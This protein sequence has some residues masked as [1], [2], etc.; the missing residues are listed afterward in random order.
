MGVQLNFNATTVEPTGSLDPIPPADYPVVLTDSEVCETRNRDGHYLK[1]TF[2]V[3]GGEHAGRQLF[4]N[5]NLWHP[6]PVASEIAWRELSGL[7]HAANVMQVQD[8][9]QLHGIPVMAKVKIEKGKDGYDDSNRISGFKN[10]NEAGGAGAGAPQGAPAQAPGG[11]PPQQPPGQGAQ[12]PQGGAAPWQQPGQQG[13]P[14][15]G[16]PPQQAAP[17]AQPPQQ[18]APPQQAQPPQ[19]TQE[20]PAQQAAPPQGD[21]NGGGTPPW[22]QGQNQAPQGGNNAGG[23]PPWAQGQQ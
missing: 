3:E 17:P 13:A 10:I 7:C 11:A 1:L 12:P 21:G 8:T 16:Q 18:A 5:L 15:Q 20:Q 14:A 9:G 6:N 19:Q 4:E 2:R 22:M 23:A